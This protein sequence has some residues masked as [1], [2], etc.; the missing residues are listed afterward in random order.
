MKKVFRTW[1]WLQ[2]LEGIL[3]VI[4]GTLIATLIWVRKSSVDGTNIS[5]I[6]HNI[7]GYV[8]AG[9]VLVNGAIMMIFTLIAKP[10]KFDMN[11]ILGTFLSALGVFIIFQ[12]Y[13]K[14]EI[15]S[16]IILVITAVLLIGIAIYLITWAA[17]KLSHKDQSRLG[18]ILGFILA[19]LC[20]AGGIVVLILKDNRTLQNISICIVGVLIALLGFFA[21]FEVMIRTY[22]LNKI[23]KSMEEAYGEEA[24]L[25]GEATIV[26]DI[27]VIENKDEDE[28]P[29]VIEHETI[30]EVDNEN[31]SNEVEEE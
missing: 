28:E 5:E 3:L 24:P 11:Y 30:V 8:V 15:I 20:I 29:K 21:L 4:V 25:G 10:L 2:I 13:E 26:E 17:R 18:P 22:R 6:I 23:R 7:I 1:R 12:V 27:E 14:P 19:G 16:T 9:T 31:D